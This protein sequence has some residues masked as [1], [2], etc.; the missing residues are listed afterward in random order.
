MAR[1]RVEA[2]Q[3]KAQ[4][5]VETIRAK[6]EAEAALEVVTAKRDRDAKCLKESGST[7]Q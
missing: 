1:H 5:A 6:Q 3:M 2:L 4:A 7:C